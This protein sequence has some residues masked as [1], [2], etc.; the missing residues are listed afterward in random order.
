MQQVDALAEIQKIRL[1]EADEMKKIISRSEHN[2]S[3]RQVRSYV[4]ALLEEKPDFTGKMVL[5]F[6]DGRPMNIETTTRT[7]I[8]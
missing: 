3:V 6:K 8:S 5:N 7:Q 1:E 2:R 4:G